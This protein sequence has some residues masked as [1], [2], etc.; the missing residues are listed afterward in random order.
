MDCDL[1]GSA[2]NR[3][4][5]LAAG[6]HGMNKVQRGPATQMVPLNRCRREFF[7]SPIARVICM[8]RGLKTPRL[9]L[10]GQACSREQL[11]LI[12]FFEELR[13]RGYRGGYDAVR[14]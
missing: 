5:R 1:T 14:G 4:L 9:T 6:H 10:R 11:T 12:R 7:S 2:R 13:G 3:R 8:P